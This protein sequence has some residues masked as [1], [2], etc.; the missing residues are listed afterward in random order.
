M[1]SSRHI[2]GNFDEALDHLRNEVLVMASL[3]ARSLSN[4][5]AGL[6]HREESR[7]ATAIADDAEIDELEK[8]LDKAGFRIMV[9]FQPVALDLRR[10]VSA[11]KIGSNLERIAD[12][13][14]N[15]ARRARKLNQVDEFE[16]VFLLEPAF[17]YAE[18][19]SRDAIQ[20]FANNDPALA[21]DVRE[22][23]GELDRMTSELAKRLT[24]LME[25]GGSRIT[26]YLNLILIG[27]HLE[28]VGDHA[29][30]IAEDVIFACSAEDVRHT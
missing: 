7:C 26:S 27:R 5:S 11:M 9:R 29:S 2:L 6:L 19:M 23:D 18:R 15:I 4:A 14:T 21:A 10:V 25:Q 13:A 20:A 30:N 22:R 24:E 3:T 12:Q 28:R 1:E 8:Q 16:E 17:L